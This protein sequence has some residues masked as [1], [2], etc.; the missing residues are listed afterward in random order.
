MSKQSLNLSVEESIKERAKRIARSQGISVS[1]FFEE[2]VV[3]EESPDEYTPEPGTA[4][5][6]IA[7]LI[8]EDKKLDHYDYDKMKMEALKE[9]Y[10][11]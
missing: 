5:Y 2:L 10:D 8:P 4:A 11:L 6:K 1:Q 9:K 7:N 3:R